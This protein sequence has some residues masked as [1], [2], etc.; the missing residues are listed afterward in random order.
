MLLRTTLLVGTAIAPLAATICLPAQAAPLVV[1]SGNE[2]VIEPPVMH[3]HET[4][5][6]VPLITNV[7]FAN[8]NVPTYSFTPP[9]ACPGPWA[10]VLLVV[11][12]SLNAGIQY[13]RS[14]LLFMAGVPLWFG[15][16]AEPNPNLAPRWHFEKDV[17]DYTALFEAPQSGSVSIGNLVN[18]TYTGI[19]TS[20]MTLYFYPPTARYPAPVTAD[21]V[22]PIPGTGGSGGLGSPTDTIATTAVFPTNI[23]R[24]K[25]DLYLQ[26]QGGDEFW[27]TCVPNALSSEL[28]S[29]GGG[30]LREGEVSVD[31]TPAGVAPIYPWIFTGGIDPYLW[32]PIPGV[33][34]FDFVPFQ[35]DLSPF[36]G[37]L[38]NGAQHT[39]SASVY[40]DNN[41]FTA[42]GAIRL[43]LDHGASTVT[44]AVIRNSLA[45]TPNVATS[46]TIQSTATG[47][48]GTV[49]T[50]DKRVFEIDGYVNGSAGITHNTVK[51]TTTFKNDQ[52]FDIASSYAQKIHQQT[53][54]S[55]IS[56]SDTG[57]V[58][59]VTTTS[60]Q[61]PLYVGYK[62]LFNA[63]GDG[64]Q[65]T[66]I[67]QQYLKQVVQTVGAQTP[68]TFN[69]TNTIETGDT[70]LFDN[71]GYITG[72][73]AQ[74]ETAY[75]LRTGSDTTCFQRSLAAAANILTVVQ[76]GC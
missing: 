20:T 74:N 25:M 12:L 55:V 10:K 38:S 2:A 39:I 27:Y 54:T 49:S 41:Y 32:Q 1:G 46:N 16:T 37:V 7:Q 65:I 59:T 64:K 62:E 35:V 70:L 63:Q 8:F 66:S 3:P 33:Q 51:Q 26:G 58:P 14:G 75:Y 67:S 21:V 48:T 69:L 47:L 76:T 60:L 71:Q 4:P 42:T 44:G 53:D 73:K 50:Q 52:S 61:W 13:D 68:I 30:A 43:F 56:T 36:A 5:C 45:A 29:C 9:A 40:G 72:N 24:A 15:T 17:T 23:L 57:G 11:D 18:S 19:I 31:T 34:T 6:A 22:L 28:E